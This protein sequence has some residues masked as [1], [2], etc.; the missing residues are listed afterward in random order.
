M[1]FHGRQLSKAWAEEKTW[2]RRRPGGRENIVVGNKW[3]RGVIQLVHSEQQQ[4]RRQGPMKL[5]AARLYTTVYSTVNYLLLWTAPGG[6]KAVSFGC[7][8][9]PRREA[10]RGRPHSGSSGS[11]DKSPGTLLR[12][13]AAAL[14]HC[15][16]APQPICQ[17]APG[18]A[19]NRPHLHRSLSLSCNCCAHLSDL[20][21]TYGT[22]VQDTGPAPRP[23]NYLL[24][25]GICVAYSVQYSPKTALGCHMFQCCLVVRD[26]MLLP[27]QS[28]SFSTSRH[29]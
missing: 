27:L 10:P 14:Q 18:R 9:T 28:G 17:H 12:Y 6:G 23:D 24:R 26:I 19:H 22:Q 16:G 29:Q 8:L 25:Y 5:E 7:S 11:S 20:A 1:N 4:S 2:F 13:R 21:C 3:C 15:T